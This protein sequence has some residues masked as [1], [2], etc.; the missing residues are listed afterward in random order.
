MPILNK[1]LSQTIVS[2]DLA[3]RLAQLFSSENALLLIFLRVRD[4]FANGLS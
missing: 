4:S 1:R 3:C 2:L